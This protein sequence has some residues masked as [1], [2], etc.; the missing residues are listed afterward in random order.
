MSLKEIRTNWLIMLAGF[1]LTVLISIGAK[2][3]MHADLPA[4]RL[5]SREA[6]KEAQG[7]KDVYRCYKVKDS[8]GTIRKA[9]GAKYVFALALPPV[10]DAK[11]F[12]TLLS[13][14]Q[15]P[16]KCEP[17]ERDGGK[18]AKVADESDDE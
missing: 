8:D 3:S 11:Q 2:A 17:M 13:D 6:I 15:R 14:K 5:K 1:G 4:T 18:W 12:D 16:V 7:G 10:I 9:K